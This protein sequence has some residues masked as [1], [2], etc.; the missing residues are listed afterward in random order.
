MKRHHDA[1]P[2]AHT[3]QPSDG[4]VPHLHPLAEYAYGS[5]LLLIEKQ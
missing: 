2:I 5:M 3:P 1:K 4:R